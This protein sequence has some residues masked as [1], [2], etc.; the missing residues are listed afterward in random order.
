MATKFFRLLTVRRPACGAAAVCGGA[1]IHAANA[2]QSWKKV[3]RG[4]ASFMIYTNITRTKVRPLA[5]IRRARVTEFCRTGSA[6]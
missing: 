6:K 4:T 3:L 2:E 1:D 5:A